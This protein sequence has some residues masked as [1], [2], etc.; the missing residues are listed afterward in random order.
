MVVV[1]SVLVALEV[2]GVDGTALHAATELVLL[3]HEPENIVGVGGGA[4]AANHALN[5]IGE[6]F[7][8]VGLSS[9]SA[10]VERA[11]VE[12]LDTL[13][14]TE[15]LETLKTGGLLDV[16]GDLAGLSSLTIEL[17]GRG[18]RGHAL[19]GGE[20]ADGGCGPGGGAGGVEEGPG[21]SSDG[22]FEH[23]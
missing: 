22:C 12:D 1:G 7:D 23:L 5:V 14:L 11:V 8:W 16:G 13:E 21:G 9:N 10:R 3:E 18:T 2:E 19:G 4:G 15:E 6:D 17:G 20:S